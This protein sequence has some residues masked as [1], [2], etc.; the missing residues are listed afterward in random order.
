MKTTDNNQ[1]KQ[2]TELSDEDL[3]QVNGGTSRKKAVTGS[4]ASVSAK[5]LCLDNLK[6]ENGNCPQK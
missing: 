4:V 3:K 2:L 1:K 6:D 5:N